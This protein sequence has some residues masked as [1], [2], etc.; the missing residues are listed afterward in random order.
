MGKATRVRT[1]VSEPGDA[2]TQAQLAKGDYHRDYVTHVETNTKAMAHVSHHDPVARWTASGRLTESQQAAI[3]HC[4]R[5]WELSGLKQALTANY[6]HVVS[7][8]GCTERQ[9]A[10]QI[11]ARRKLQKLQD[12]CP[13]DAW[14][15]FENVCR[16]GEPAGV[17]G[18][19]LGYE[20]RSAQAV[21]HVMVCIVADIVA[22]KERF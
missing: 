5:L 1:R 20:P 4:S 11:D 12:A 21:A 19:A 7:G 8:A 9:A 22:M 16:W 14:D 13:P 17:A 6:G 15:V 2:P 3:R 10:R 18:S